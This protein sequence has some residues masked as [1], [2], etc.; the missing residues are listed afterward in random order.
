MDVYHKVL[1]K[2]Y[3][4]TGGKDSQTVDLKD[5]VKGQGFLGN[6]NDIFQM[7]N[8]QG[9]IVETPKLNY[10]KITHW[11][12]KEAKKADNSVANSSQ[13]DNAQIVKKEAARLIADTKQLLIILEEF[14][15]DSSKENYTQV[16]KKLGE[17][18]SAIGSLKSS[19]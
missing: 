15:L 12:V 6:Y 9:W 14:A 11:G 7:L 2:L 17:I 19:I 4:V 8:G 13:T 16:V 5:L 3:E 1:H 10:V 18:N